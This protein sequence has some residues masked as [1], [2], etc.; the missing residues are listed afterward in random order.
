MSRGGPLPHGL[1]GDFKAK[2]SSRFYD[3]FNYITWFQDGYH[4]EYIVGLK[5]SNVKGSKGALRLL[6][7]YG[8]FGLIVPVLIVCFLKEQAHH[9]SH[10][11]GVRVY[12]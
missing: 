12:S 11:Y 10:Y 7:R 5:F 9:V 1:P 4:S 6:I 8:L 3:D 2:E